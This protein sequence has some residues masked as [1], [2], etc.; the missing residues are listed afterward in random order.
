MTTALL[1]TAIMN[2]A[3]GLAFLPPAQPLRALVG[4]PDGEPVYLATARATR[5]SASRVT[6]SG[7]S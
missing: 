5:T 3:A 7:C 2:L 6:T 4:M 1:A